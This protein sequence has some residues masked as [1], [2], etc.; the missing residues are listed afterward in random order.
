MQTVHGGLAANDLGRISMSDDWR[1]VSLNPELQRLLQQFT[2]W[3][4]Q[5]MK[6]ITEANEPREPVFHYTNMEGMRGIISNNK[7]WYTSIIHLNDPSE[8]HYGIDMARDLLRA[9]SKGHGQAV[10]VFCEWMEHVLTEVRDNIFGF[11]VACFSQDPDDL[12]QWRAYADNGRGVAIGFKF[13]YVIDAAKLGI[14]EK[15]TVGRVIYDPAVCHANLTTVITT[16]ISIITRGE[17]SLTSAAEHE[18]FGR[19]VANELAILILWYA[20]TCK[21]KA[22]INEKEIRLMLWGDI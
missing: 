6:E 19:S 21:H 9:Q 12:G 2:N 20:L 10:E 15:T 5:L 13:Q 22:Y 8:L 4:D 18:A 14:T 11:F 1:Q 17:P 3:R 7:I 16:A